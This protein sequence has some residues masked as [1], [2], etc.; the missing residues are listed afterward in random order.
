[1]TC[2]SSQ[3][4]ALVWC[5]QF[6]SQLPYWGERF[7]VRESEK[8]SESSVA[9]LIKN[10]PNFKKKFCFLLNGQITKNLK[11]YFELNNKYNIQCNIA[12]SKV[13]QKKLT[14]KEIQR[15]LEFEGYYKG[16]VDGIS[17]KNTSK[18]IKEWQKIYKFIETGHLSTEQNQFML[19]SV[20]DKFDYKLK[21]SS[22]IENKILS[23][24]KKTSSWVISIK[25]YFMDLIST[26]DYWIDKIFYW[27]SNIAGSLSI[28]SI[29]LWI[30]LLPKSDKRTRSGY[31]DNAI[32]PGCGMPIF[33]IVS[34]LIAYF[35]SK[36]GFFYAFFY[37]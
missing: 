34:G 4:W 33:G 19:V 3:S 13:I 8:I 30:I 31:K 25:S 37:G 6:S 16:K 28:L 26:I 9:N 27:I 29:L 14:I 18:A 22:E 32:P 35:I 10:S 2:I 17:G 1:M 20:I 7:C 15:I 36:D 12:S 5:Q 23:K 24:E 21:S 11:P